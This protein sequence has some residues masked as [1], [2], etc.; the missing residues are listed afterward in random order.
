MLIYLAG[1][2]HSHDASVAACKPLLAKDVLY[3]MEKDFF[4]YES[5]DRNIKKILTDCL[6]EEVD[7][8]G[9]KVNDCIVKI[10]WFSEG[11]F[12]I[13]K[14]HNYVRGAHDQGKYNV[15]TFHKGKPV[16]LSAIQGNA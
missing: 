6:F 11:R 15:Y 1:C 8:N 3:R 16:F 13:R 12:G 9:D 2:A 5:E 14:G 4:H 7:L 10:N